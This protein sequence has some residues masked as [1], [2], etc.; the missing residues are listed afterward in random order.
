MD[1]CPIQSVS[2]N[3]KSSPCAE[4]LKSGSWTAGIALFLFAEAVIPGV[5]DYSDR[6]AQH[7]S[8]HNEEVWLCAFDALALDGNDLRD[9]PLS[10]M[11]EGV[12][13]EPTVP[14]RVRRFSRPVP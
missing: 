10:L 6:N 14:L 11:A 3:V 5:D 1:P 8:K 2:S 7:S 4:T 9:L 13:F 12:G